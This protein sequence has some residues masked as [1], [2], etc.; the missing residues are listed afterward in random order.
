MIT[1]EQPERQPSQR[2]PPCAAFLVRYWRDG[3]QWRIVLEDVASREQ[4]GFGSLEA[5][6][7]ALQAMLADNA[8][9][10]D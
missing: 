5:F 10:G 9:P 2:G 6:L 7:E 3:A 1:D 4:W 8:F